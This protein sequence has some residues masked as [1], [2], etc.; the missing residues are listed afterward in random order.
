MTY[1]ISVKLINDSGEAL[2]IIEKS[3]AENA[4]WLEQNGVQKLTM[5]ASGTSGVLRFQGGNGE[6]FL[7]ALGVHNYKHWSSVLVDLDGNQT[8]MRIHPTYYGNNTKPHWDQVPEMTKTTAKG[9][10]VGIY[11][12]KPTGEDLRAVIT[13]A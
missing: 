7:V 13:Y 8:A 10:T 4:I 12:Y 11:Y 5:D 9:K 1:T 3:C 2:N 6:K